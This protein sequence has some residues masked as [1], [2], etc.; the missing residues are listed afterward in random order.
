VVWHKGRVVFGPLTSET[1]GPGNS[2]P[3]PPLSEGAINQALRYLGVWRQNGQ[4]EFDMLGLG[5]YRSAEAVVA[6]A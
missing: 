4:D 3:A 2:Y 1:A 6:K 5:Q